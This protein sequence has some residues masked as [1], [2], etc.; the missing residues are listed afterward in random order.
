VSAGFFA[1]PEL[2]LLA[3]GL[4]LELAW[5]IGHAPLYTMWRAGPWPAI[6]NHV[7]HCNFGDLVILLVCYEA[8]TWS[9]R[10]RWW[11]VRYRAGDV[12]AFT[13]LGFA[14]T[15]AAELY[16]LQVAHSWAYTVAMPLV[17][18]LGLGLTPLLQWL[19]LPPILLLL[20]SRF[21]RPGRRR[22]EERDDNAAETRQDST[23]IGSRSPHDS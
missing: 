15:V 8:L 4:P 9:R 5:E 7:L 12:L 21:A 13:L 19:V 18:G 22:R 6:A 3:A 11:W 16:H 1:S 14:I 17:P 10:D 2:R 23:L 20:L